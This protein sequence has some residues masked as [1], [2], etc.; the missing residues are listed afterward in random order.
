MGEL[1]VSGFFDM[2]AK[3]EMRR[4]HPVPVNFFTSRRRVCAGALAAAAALLLAGCDRQSASSKVYE[5]GEE[6]ATGSL[7]YV[8][9]QTTWAEQLEGPAGLRIPTNKFLMV[10]VTVKN[11]GRDAAGVPLLAVID[12][13]GKEYM[14]LDKGDGVPQWLGALRTLLA[15]ASD[16]G[17]ML[18]DVPQGTY[19]LRVSSGGDVEKESTALVNMPYGVESGKT[20][21]AYTLPTPPGK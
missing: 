11:A 9:T 8:V 12:T 15:G 2:V 1:H 20:A 3:V 13:G 4:I 18:F 7:V 16:S 6:I 21:P 5:M 19:K 17:N 14:E 10:N